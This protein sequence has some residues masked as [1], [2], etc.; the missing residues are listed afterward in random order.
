[1]NTYYGSYRTRTF[2]EIFPSLEK[3]REDLNETP[4]KTVLQ[5]K[6]D[7]PA[8]PLD[9]AYGLLFAR[10]GNSHSTFASEDIFRYNI[11][12]TIFMYGPAWSKRLQLQ[13]KVRQI[14]EEETVIGQTEISNH[15]QNPNTV[16]TTQTLEEL[17]YINA[18]NVRKH[19]RNKLEAYASVMALLES[20]VSEEFITKFRKFFIQIIAPDTPLLYATNPAD[21]EPVEQ[22]TEEITIL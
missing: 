6:G 22:E 10:Y 3:F 1:M 5:T 21:F 19:R 17:N 18:Q 13:Q 15:A 14:T 20:D 2:S 16:P 8:F 7:E 11:F 12:A 9:V 4:F